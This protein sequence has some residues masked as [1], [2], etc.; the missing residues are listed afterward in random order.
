VLLRYRDQKKEEHSFY[1]YLKNAQIGDRNRRASNHRSHLSL[2]PIEKLFPG[3]N[4]ILVYRHPTTDE[5]DILPHEQRYPGSD[6][7]WKIP[8][9]DWPTVLARI[10]RGEPLRKVAR[11]YGVSYEAVRRVIRAAH[12]KTG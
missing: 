3:R 5:V 7:H 4:D 10:N 9:S 2:V 11:E 1:N 6:P 12:K 8:V